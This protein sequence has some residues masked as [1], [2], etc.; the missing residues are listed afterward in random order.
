MSFVVGKLKQTHPIKQHI[1][2]GLMPLS[3]GILLPSVAMLYM[4]GTL[5]AIANKTNKGVF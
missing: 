2:Y 4:L 3:F 1:H 5:Y